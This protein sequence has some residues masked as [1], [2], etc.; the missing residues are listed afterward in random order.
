MESVEEIKKKKMDALIRK[1][2]GAKM[3]SVLEVTDGSFGKEVIEKSKEKPVIVDFYADWCAPCKMISPVLE[4]VVAAYSEKVILTKL[5]T[6]MNPVISNSA[7]ISS[8]PAIAM[9]KGGKI[10]SGFIGFK[11][12]EQVKNWIDSALTG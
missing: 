12:E 9:F 2:E 8:I 4:K 10:V 6:D 1:K 11:S 5:N 7:G 3:V